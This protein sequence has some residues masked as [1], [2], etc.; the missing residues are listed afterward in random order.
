MASSLQTLVKILRLEQSKGHK[1]KAVIGGFGRFA[2]HWARE[3]HSQAKS[4]EHHA[5]VDDIAERLRNYENLDEAERPAIV[6]AIIQLAVD[7]DPTDEQPSP[8]I[9]TPDEGVAFDEPEVETH[10]ESA[11]APEDH[12]VEAP[13]SV[14]ERRGYAWQQDSASE[15]IS[16]SALNEPVSSLKGVG[17]TRAEQLERIGAT[18]V[19]DLLYLFPHRYD[20]YSQMKPISRLQPTEVVSV[21]G[22]LERVKAIPMKRGKRVEAFLDDGSGH[23]RL[24]WFN[25]PWMEH[26]LEAGQAVVVSGKIEQYLGR[27]VLNNPDLEAVDNDSLHTGRIVPIYPLTKG[28]GARTMRNLMKDVVDAWTPYLPDHLPV[29]VRDRADL[30]DYGDAVGQAHFPDSLED[31]QDARH[32]LAFDELF[33]YQMGMLQQRHIWQ[34]RTGTPLRVGDDWL[35]SLIAGLPYQLTGAQQHALEDIRHDMATDLPMNRLLQGDVGS[36]KTVIAAVAIGMAIENGVQAALMAPTSILAEQHAESLSQLLVNS[37]VGDSFNLALLTGSV[38]DSERQDIYNGLATGDINIVIGT[39]ALIQDNVAFQNLGLAIIDE[40]HRFGVAQRGTLRDKAAEGNP[41]LLVMT[42]TPIPRTLALTL[43]ADLDLTVMDEMPPGREPV[44]T[45]V[46]QPKERERAYAYIRSQIEQRNQAYIVYALIE[47]SEKIAASGAVDA[48]ERLS[49]NVFPD[50]QLGLLH[51][52]MSAYEK[53]SVMAAFYAGEIDVL[54]STTVIEVGIDVPNATVMM[55]EDANRFGLAQLH[56]L[57]GRVGRGGNEGYCILVA[58]QPFLDHDPRLSAL[59]ETTD[60][61]KLA[62]IDWELRG[63]G[64]L[65]GQRQSGFGVTTFAN[66]MDP[67]L[68][69]SVQQQAWRIYESDPVLQLPE[70][71]ELRN[72]V[73]HL[74]ATRESGDIS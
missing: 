67:K 44:K 29:D 22:M 64:D 73:S 62:E 47:E 5:L 28:M 57:R 7:F 41:H 14:R 55:V 59:E 32:R 58:D 61:F 35:Q 21:I 27:L 49:E 40:Q 38:S 31:L 43:H 46:I 3:A 18:T 69:E 72:R 11:P 33:I 13:D 66:L 1:N 74:R 24:N 16:L 70:H 26:Q 17:E 37:P 53:E 15:P 20:D 51:G 34:S 10:T 19:G 52:R 71:A 48:F 39:H 8:V 30:M 2:Y 6:E 65:L 36:G 4:E 63:A 50:L 12:A 68:V 25:Q 60:G 56:Q 54:V 23:L 42:A 45:R 9:S